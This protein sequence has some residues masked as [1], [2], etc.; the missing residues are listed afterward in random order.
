MLL[1]G[2]DSLGFT[3]FTNYKSQ[4][5]I[6]IEHNPFVASSFYWSWIFLQLRIEGKVEKIDVE[7]SKKYFYSRPI[8][9]QIAARASKQSQDLKSR[10][11]LLEKVERERDKFENQVVPYPD[12]WGGFKIYPSKFEFWQG[13]PD[14]LHDRIVYEKFKNSWKMHRIYP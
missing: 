11:E 3:F 2:F 1:K 12:D 14:R 10:K 7:M 9:R 6:D 4:K 8:S 13:Q 5:A